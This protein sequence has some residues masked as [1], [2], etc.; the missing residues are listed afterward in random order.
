[1]NTKTISNFCVTYIQMDICQ[2]DIITLLIIIY[3]RSA[4]SFLRVLN[5]HQNI[6]LIRR[7]HNLMFL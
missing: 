7:N 5:D 4:L 1:M 3:T 6:V 2:P